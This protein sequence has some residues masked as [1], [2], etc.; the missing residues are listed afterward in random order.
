VLPKLL[1]AAER[2]AER[3]DD[4]EMAALDVAPLFT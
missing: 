4:A 1:D 2:Y 3:P